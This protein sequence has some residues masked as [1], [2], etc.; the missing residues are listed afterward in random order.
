MRLVYIGPLLASL[1]GAVPTASESTFDFTRSMLARAPPEAHA[2]LKY[3]RTN[4]SGCAD[5]SASFLVQDDATVLFDTFTLVPTSPGTISR[6]CTITFDL[7][8][9]PSWKCA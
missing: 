7:Q 9:D 4:G 1:A 3:S 8:L 6:I 2:I 5:N